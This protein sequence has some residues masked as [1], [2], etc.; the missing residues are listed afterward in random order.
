MSLV[1]LC[2]LGNASVSPQMNW[3]SW[4][5]SGCLCLDCCPCNPNLDKQ[6]KMGGQTDSWSVCLTAVWLPS[7][8][9]KPTF[10][11]MAAKER[12]ELL[13]SLLEL[14][15]LKC[16]R[17]LK[18]I[19][20]TYTDFTMWNFNMSIHHC[21]SGYITEWNSKM[22]VLWTNLV[23]LLRL[24]Q[25]HSVMLSSLITVCML[26]VSVLTFSLALWNHGHAGF[27]TYCYIVTINQT[28]S[29]CV[30]IGIIRYLVP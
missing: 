29:W 4:Q 23:I 8:S 14:K 10:F 18:E 9:L 12:V 16:E 1:S 17:W 22:I 13:C 20:Y 30:I 25:R 3:R 28:A 26:P 5:G 6:Q 19:P 7:R 11:W 24:A 15:S 27:W 21:N 2:W